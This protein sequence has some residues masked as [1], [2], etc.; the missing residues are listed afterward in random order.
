MTQVLL[1]VAPPQVTDPSALELL[2]DAARR[3][4]I[5]FYLRNKTDGAFEGSGV[6]WWWELVNGE[7]WCCADVQPHIANIAGGL[8]FNHAMIALRTGTIDGRRVTLG[9][10]S[11]IAC[12]VE[13]GNVAPQ[14]RKLPDGIKPGIVERLRGRAMRSRAVERYVAGARGVALDQPA[15]HELPAEFAKPHA[16]SIAKLA[17]NGQPHA[18][19]WAR[20]W[21]G[22]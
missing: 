6:A 12:H 1:R 10:A 9:F 14:L 8:N 16:K 21:A 4:A 13:V 15:V 17:A 20:Y 19:A 18:M 22:A 3:V 7:I 11:V 5:P 2:V